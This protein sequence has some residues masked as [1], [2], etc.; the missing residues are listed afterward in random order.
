M[1]GIEPWHPVCKRDVN[2][3]HSNGSKV[4]TYCMYPIGMVRLELKCVTHEIV[5][6]GLPLGRSPSRPTLI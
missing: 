5:E 6:L 1:H 3:T 2:W 4:E